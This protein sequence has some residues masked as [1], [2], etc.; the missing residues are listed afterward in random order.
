[1]NIIEELENIEKAKQYVKNHSMIYQVD[2]KEEL[3]RKRGLPT[4]VY[5]DLKFEDWTMI[6]KD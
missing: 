2:L 4:N 1:M 3:A 5:Y 6:R